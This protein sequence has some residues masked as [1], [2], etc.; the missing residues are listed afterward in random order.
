MIRSIHSQVIGLRTL[1]STYGLL[2]GIVAA[3]LVMVLA[4]LGSNLGTAYVEP[5]QVREPVMI[6]VGVIVSIMVC[7]FAATGV[8]GDYRYRTIS[9]RLLAVPRRSRLLLAHLVTY[10]TFGLVVAAAAMGL[11][12]AI[13]QPLVAGQDLS[14]GLTAAGVAGPVVA[15]PLFAVIGVGIGT[16]CRSQA[17]AV[18]VIVGWFPAEKLL[19][20]VLGDRAAYL[21]YGLVSQL[22]GLEGATVS[23]GAAVLCL[24]G[25][26]A[27]AGLLAAA[28]LARRDVN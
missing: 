1:R 21:P 11:A 7:V 9:L 27:A 6:A 25:Y 8:A 17:A 2:A 3:V 19:G 5:L 10:T 15:V 24:S 28:V 13:A 18:L 14:L 12:L 26:A 23:R 4:D 16:I 22:L 20:L